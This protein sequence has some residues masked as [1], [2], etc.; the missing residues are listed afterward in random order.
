[1]KLR[2]FSLTL[3]VVM[4][5]SS[6][7][8]CI[9][10]A[11]T[12]PTGIADTQGNEP[13]SGGSLTF[14]IAEE[15]PTLNPYLSQTGWEALITQTIYE[16]LAAPGPDGV[17]Y[18]VLAKELPTP[19]NGGVSADGLMITWKLRE[20]IRWSDGQPFTA[21]DVEFTWEAVTHPESGATWAPGANLIKEVEVPDKYTVVINYTQFYPDYL[22]QFTSSST[23]GQGI[24][25]K[26]ICGE[27]AQMPEW[28]C[29]RQPVGTGP[30]V[31]AEWKTGQYLR[32]TRNPFYHEQGKPILD[33]IVFP[34]VPDSAVHKQMMVRGDAHV[35]F[36]VDQLYLIELSNMDTIQLNPGSE[37]WV[38]R[39]FFNLSERG[40][41]DSSLPHPILADDRVRRA[42]NLAL[43]RQVINEGAIGG[44]AKPASH[45][46]YHGLYACPEPDLVFDP[47]A[48]QSL[49][50]EAGWIDTDG[51]GIRECHQCLHGSEGQQMSLVFVISSKG[52]SRSLAQQLI[53]DMLID[54]GINVQARIEENSIVNDTALNGNFD[55]LMWN[56]GYEAI[57]D[58]REFLETYYASSSIPP[59]AWNI[60]R[61]ENAEVDD[62]L[63]LSKQV[64]D[65]SARQALY[66][67]IDQV[68]IDEVPVA[69]LLVMPFPS[70]FSAQVE[71][72][73]AN[74]NAI[75]TW[76]SANWLFRK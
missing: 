50:E 26:H 18:P 5:V 34:I 49:L 35:W 75:L 41:N 2:T 3:L 19:E 1:M 70:A 38:L 65:V 59:A 64:V 69:F 74:A 17:F 56:D 23:A 48:A 31:L 47:E 54:I 7:V 16:G 57:S 12:T 68:L 10:P 33:E 25:P 11:T 8:A 32:L 67:Q 24:L 30:F 6:L 36:E 29:N 20:D 45:E 73:Q 21:E 27:P 63:D 43:D 28:D 39:L 40:A 15:P 44:L 22:G 9:S 4:M 66:C 14:P 55:L 71:G 76:D 42:I 37:Q 72:W 58:P 46:L 13:T 53:I 62:L 60:M 61:F 51:D 52:E